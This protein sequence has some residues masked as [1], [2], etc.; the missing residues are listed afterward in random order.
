MNLSVV[1]FPNPVI[2]IKGKE[3]HF[4]AEQ[5]NGVYGLLNVD[6]GGYEAKDYA[7][8]I[9]LVEH[10]CPG[11]KVSWATMINGILMCDFI[12]EA[13]ILL[14]IICRRVSPTNNLKNVPTMHV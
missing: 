11:R 10:L 7:P 6:I 1:K 4:G 5:I 2:R 3:V 9:L 8:G 12:I 13:G 14:S